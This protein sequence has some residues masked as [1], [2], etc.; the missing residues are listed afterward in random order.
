MINIGTSLWN[1]YGLLFLILFG[2]TTLY[3]QPAMLDPL[4]DG[5]GIV[6]TAIGT[7]FEGAHAILLQPDKKIILAG[8][9]N[10]SLSTASFDY[11]FALCRYLTDGS[12]D[13]SFSSDGIV[14]IDFFG[15][16]NDFSYS[17]IL[18]PDGKII[19]CGRAFVNGNTN[20]GFA[21][22][23][24]NSDGSFDLSFSGDG[25]LIYDFNTGD[26]L[27][28]KAAL[29]SNGKIVVAGYALNFSNFK[30]QIALIRIDST[31]VVDNTFGVSG[32]VFTEVGPFGDRGLDMI[33][34][35][36]DKILVA[37]R[38][39]NGTDYDYA[40]VKYDSDG[41]LDLSFGN[42][43]K[44]ST[45]IAGEDDYGNSLAV[46]NDGKIIVAGYTGDIAAFTQFAMVRY[47][48][49]GVV[50]SGF[51]VNGKVVTAFTSRDQN[52]AICLQADQKILLAG[53]VYDGLDNNF[54][55]AR[56]GVDGILDSSFNI[57]GK[58]I[59]PI[60][61]NH[62]EAFAI[63]FQQDGKI[64]VAG[65]AEMNLTDDFAMIRIDNLN[66][67]LVPA[68][69]EKELLS[70]FPNPVSDGF[71]LNYQIEYSGPMKIYLADAN[72]AIIKYISI[73]QS[74]VPGM[75]N[76]RIDVSDLGAGIYFV[77]IE[78]DRI[79]KVFK[80]VKT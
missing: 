6:T 21:I 19:V 3:S 9:S 38:T 73:D 63:A 33:V 62:D 10:S 22:A 40:L 23:R 58:F 26:D 29:Q 56:Y 79:N 2:S 32:E 11:D 36:N 47:D 68:N 52:Y 45:D 14:T 17:T 41:N 28:Y 42:S 66:P 4:F 61:P 78:S 80:L 51:G 53:R 1:K 64:I 76:R 18:Q 37:G 44:V 30:Q 12:L 5:D 77:H 43:G 57:D 67:T 35:P 50:D 39:D 75:F 55:I 69:F 71:T 15:S 48:S 54:A 27:S 59:I 7:Q 46:Q 16:I 49:L 65:R 13:S 24:L 25:K 72:G 74:D 34:L 20:Y 8:Y 31:G 60:S 70:F